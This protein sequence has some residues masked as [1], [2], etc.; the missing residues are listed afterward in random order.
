MNVFKKLMIFFS[1]LIMCMGIAACSVEEKNSSKDQ[2]DEAIQQSNESKSQNDEIQVTSD[3]TAIES[4]E[5]D[6]ASTREYN[7]EIEGRNW[8]VEGITVKYPMLVNYDMQE[9]SD[10]ANDLIMNDMSNLIETIKSDVNDETLT[11]DGAFDYSQ[12]SQNVLSI[13]YNINYYADSL[14]YPVNLYH[15]IT[16]SLDQGALIP[17]SDLF[18]IEEAFVED[19]KV[20]MYAPYM[21][22]LDLESSGY[23]ISELISQQYSNE[24]LIKLFSQANAAYYLS[25]QGLIISIEV[26]HALGDHLE[27]AMKYEFLEAYMKRDHFLWKNYMFLAEP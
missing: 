5:S 19:F 16:I 9:K 8:N 6:V 18:I 25:D 2:K 23:S 22:D 20:W 10:E 15:T 4:N 3:E 12:I 13:Y 17:L 27:M 7:F 14:A 11:I 21:E 26:P 24:D 1:I